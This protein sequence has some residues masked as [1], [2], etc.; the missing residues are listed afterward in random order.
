MASGSNRSFYGI[1]KKKPAFKN[2]GGLYKNEGVKIKLRT[3]YG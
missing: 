1:L 2:E 3:V